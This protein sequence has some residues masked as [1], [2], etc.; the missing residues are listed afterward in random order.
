M[1][2]YLAAQIIGDL[3]NIILLVVGGLALAWYKS[4]STKGSTIAHGSAGDAT[5]KALAREVHWAV[6]DRNAVYN[7]SSGNAEIYKVLD[8]EVQRRVA[9]LKAHIE[10]KKS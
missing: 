3:F 6:E 4:R 5:L 2:S 1:S 8:A 7:A 10:G 9:A